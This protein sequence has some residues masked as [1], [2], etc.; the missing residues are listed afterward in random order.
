[1]SN[2]VRIAKMT[3]N[4]Q[5]LNYFKMNIENVNNLQ[6]T[7]YVM[8]RANKTIVQQCQAFTGILVSWLKVRGGLVAHVML[9]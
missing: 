5:Y 7:Y 9:V 3:P 6:F 8:L 2:I 4:F 1:M